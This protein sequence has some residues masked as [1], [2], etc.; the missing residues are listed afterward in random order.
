MLVVVGPHDPALAPLARA[1]GAA[2]LSLPEA[3]A[4]MRA[5]VEHGLRWLEERFHPRPDDAWFLAPADHPTLDAD[6]VRRLCEAY[7]DPAIPIYPGSGVRGA[8]R[9]SDAARLAARRRR[10]ALPDG[11]G[12]NAYLRS[13]VEDIAEVPAGSDAVLCDL[14]TPEDYE[15]L[16]REIG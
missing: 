7:A 13:H 4:D 6:V 3:T 5:T 9:P 15:R 2:V 11:Q 12:I 1:A 8:A 14:D 16:W 10:S